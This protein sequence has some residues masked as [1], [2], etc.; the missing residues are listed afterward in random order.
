MPQEPRIDT[1]RHDVLAR[2]A[3]SLDIPAPEGAVPP[4]WHW[5]AFLDAVP[6]RSL[7]PDGHPRSGGLI[8]DPP[9][10]RRMFAG[11]RLHWDRPLPLD[12]EIERHI[13]VGETT[14]KSGRNGPLAFVTVTLHYTVDGVKVATE[15][16]DLVYRPEPDGPPA[17]DTEATREPHD[18]RATPEPSPLLEGEPEP[19]LRADVILGP[20]HLFRFSALTFN[21]HRI[22]YD[23]P[24]A[25]GVEGYPGLVVHGPLL[26]IRLAELVRAER[27]DDVVG[28]FSF[29]A[30][31]PA[32]A[33]QSLSFLAWKTEDGYRLAARRGPA[34]LMAA[35][36][37]LRGG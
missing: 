3:A 30:M 15:E 14:H 13:S 4:L 20:E 16:Q 9:Y 12:A 8:P 27:S 25:T 24:Y 33:G 18:A 10:P 31:A 23:L 34:T 36:V 2:L 28:G 11:G 21:T 6:T 35:E 26:A 1:V 17:T 29:R 22:H 5:T 19:D 7:G 37:V 32:F